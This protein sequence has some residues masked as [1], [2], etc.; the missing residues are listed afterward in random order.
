MDDIL[1]DL[2][3]LLFKLSGYH[4]VTTGHKG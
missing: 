4:M 2:L 3:I 1:F